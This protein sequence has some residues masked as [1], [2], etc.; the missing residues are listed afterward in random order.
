MDLSLKINY[1]ELKN[2]L[3]KMNV[4][5]NLEYKLINPDEKY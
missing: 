1:D 5:L 3:I 2:I 4:D